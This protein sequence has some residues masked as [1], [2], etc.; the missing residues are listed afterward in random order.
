MKIKLMISI[1]STVI[2]ILLVHVSMNSLGASHTTIDV[3]RIK[4]NL[5]CFIFTNCNTMD[6][7]IN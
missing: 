1:T 5:E 3:Q 4:K 6:T 2:T 7:N